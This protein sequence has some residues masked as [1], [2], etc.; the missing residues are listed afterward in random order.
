MPPGS[1]WP[2]LPPGVTGEVLCF[3]WIVGVGYR[4]TVIDTSLSA[5]HPMAP[6]PLT[7][8]GNRPPGSGDGNHPSNRPP[9]S[10]GGHPSGQPV[11]PVATP[12]QP[13]AK[14]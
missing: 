1:V 10:G 14:P 13:A 6:P 12:N 4:W 5:E 7:H 3:V 11:P 8:P 2:P 9:G